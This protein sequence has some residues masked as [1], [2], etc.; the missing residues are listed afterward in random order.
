MMKAILA[1]FAALSFAATANADDKLNCENPTANVE[2]G[3]CT[4]LGFEKADKELNMIWP[5]MK[6]AAQDSDTENDNHKNIDALLASQR[7]WLAFLEAECAWQA[8]HQM[9][10]GSGGPIVY[11]GCKTD[12]TKQRIKQLQSGASQ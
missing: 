2:I 12:L 5:K 4:V 7:T 11:W 10:G 8:L 3:Q 6:A 9:Q 1:L